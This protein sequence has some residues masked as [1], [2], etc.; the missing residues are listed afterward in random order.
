VYTPFRAFVQENPVFSNMFPVLVSLLKKQ[1][2]RDK[3][4]TVIFHLTTVFFGG[5]GDGGV[6]ATGETGRR[7]FTHAAKKAALRLFLNAA[8][9]PVASTK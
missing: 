1:E 4:N 9:N 5:R 3:K 2:Y 8:S 6:G 7:D